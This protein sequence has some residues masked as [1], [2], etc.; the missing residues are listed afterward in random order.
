MHSM[1]Y[2]L[3]ASS[4]ALLF[5]CNALLPM[6]T[7][8]PTVV[9]TPQPTANASPSTSPALSAL[10]ESRA[11][12]LD[13]YKI[14]VAQHI[15]SANAG[16]TFSGRLPPMLPAIVIVNIRLEGN[17]NVAKA[18]VQRSRDHEASRIAIASVLRAAPYPKPARQLHSG[19]NLLEFSETFLFD[20]DYRFQ[21][22]TLAGP[23]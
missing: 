19:R 23:Q 9:A 15:L 21:L 16:H 10:N 2:A 5:G 18:I 1:K 22:R 4:V 3:I 11:R 13:A 17:G 8:K 6:F 20:D 14:D 7:P 12:H